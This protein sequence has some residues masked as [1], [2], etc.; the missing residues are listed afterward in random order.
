MSE[1]HVALACI[2]YGEHSDYK[3]CV[4]RGQPLSDLE[5]IQRKR[6]NKGLA[7]ST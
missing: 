5:R 7:R 6:Q 4:I 1:D 2:H 3:D